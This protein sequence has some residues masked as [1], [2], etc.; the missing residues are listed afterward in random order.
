MVHDTFVSVGNNFGIIGHAYVYIFIFI[1]IY[2]VL[3][4]NIAIIEDA[5][6]AEKP[7]STRHGH[8]GIDQTPAV[9]PRSLNNSRGTNEPLEIWTL[10]E[11]RCNSQGLTPAT[12]RSPRSCG[13]ASGSSQ[14]MSPRFINN[15][16]LQ[17]AMDVAFARQSVAVSQEAAL[18]TADA[19]VQLTERTRPLLVSEGLPMHDPEVCVASASSQPR[20]STGSAPSDPGPVA[21]E[22]CGVTEDDDRWVHQLAE[23]SRALRRDRPP[24]PKCARARKRLF[25]MLEDLS[26]SASEAAALLQE[27]QEERS[28]GLGRSHPEVTTKA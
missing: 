20:L 15:P 17:Q 28:P 18:G 7:H 13:D 16:R 11:D 22:P 23:W 3:N 21:K 27:P 24:L 6:Y 2:V 25:A 1:F 4:I 10:D 14:R 12:S 26:V 9:E 19:D 5:Y 8:G